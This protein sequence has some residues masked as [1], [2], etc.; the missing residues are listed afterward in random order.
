MDTTTTPKISVIV[1]VYKVEQYLPKC[2]DSILAQTF[3]DFELLLIDDGS[4]DRSGEICDEYAAKD[5]R[6]RVFHK[7]NG[8]VSS[9]R[10][11]GLDHALG[12]WI[13]FVDSDDWVG[14]SYFQ[15]FIENIGT[16]NLLIQGF[17]FYNQE[18]D[19]S[20]IKKKHY[21]K[22]LIEGCDIATFISSN[23]FNGAIN[24][25]W[26]K[27]FNR[28]CIVNNHLKFNPQ[29]SN[30]EDY[31]FVISYFQYIQTIELIDNYEYF[32]RRNHG[33]NLSLRV[34]PF[35]ERKLLFENILHVYERISEKYNY[36]I[37]NFNKE[38][39]GRAIL[40]AESLVYKTTNCIAD[41]EYVSS[42]LKKHKVDGA[43][44]SSNYII[45]L[46]IQTKYYGFMLF[47]SKSKI[48]FILCRIIIS[49]LA[50]IKQS[51]I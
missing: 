9:A 27:L 51:L 10:N 29:I 25:P 33:G 2:I 19:K 31:L 15:K 21:S 11:M 7:E 41:Y 17:I 40:M 20:I 28:S 30:G 3:T 38:L 13:A 14:N 8:G 5:S 32:V 37:E 35:E 26:I 36:T 46:S 23:E 22:N 34:P 18:F 49:I 6:I 50:R 12:E 1:P 16:N 42:I 48:V 39:F 44:Y 47:K 24:S 43:V 45:H 4:P